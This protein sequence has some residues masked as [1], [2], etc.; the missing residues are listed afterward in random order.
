MN[1]EFGLIHI[2]CGDGKGKT[3]AAMG[4]ALRA[5]GCGGRVLVV[6]FLKDGD[7]SELNALKAFPG[8]NV[9]TGKPVKGFSF[10]MTAAE[11]QLVAKH[12]NAYLQQAITLCRDQQADM[13]ILDEIIGALNKQLV[14]QDFLLDFLRNKPAQLE[15]VMTGR[16]PSSELVELADYVSEI[17]KIKHPYDQ[18]IKSRIGVE[19]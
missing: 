19:K 9:L 4:L 13:L 16:N 1:S 14:N 7:S 3:T 17:N 11:Q 10:A 2:Y 15:V 5:L 12:H 6:Q 18:G 8:V